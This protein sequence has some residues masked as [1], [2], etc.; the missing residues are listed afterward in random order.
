M[1]PSSLVEEVAG[2]AVKAVSCPPRHPIQFCSR[3]LTRRN[4]IPRLA[5]SATCCRPASPPNRHLHHPDIGYLF[6]GKKTQDRSGKVTGRSVSTRVDRQAFSPVTIT[7]TPTDLDRLQTRITRLQGSAACCSMRDAN[8]PWA[9]STCAKQIV[10]TRH[11]R[12]DLSIDK[13]ETHVLSGGCILLSKMQFLGE[14]S[15]LPSLT[16]KQ[17]E[18]AVI[19]SQYHAIISQNASPRTYPPSRPGPVARLVPLHG[20]LASHS[21]RVSPST[22]SPSTESM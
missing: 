22:R 15:A 5:R 6:F 20:H 9:Y 13:A 12:R 17:E 18:R 16:K 4:C 19:L 2:G 7:E 1:T 14:A 11:A 21:S 3:E 10:Q 8:P